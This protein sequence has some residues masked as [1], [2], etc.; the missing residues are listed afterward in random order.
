MSSRHREVNNSSAKTRREKKQDEDLLLFREMFK[1]EKE[2]NLSLLQQESVEL[3]PGQGTYQLHKIPL[4]KKDFLFTESSKNDYDWLKTPPATP[5]FPSLEMEV[6]D[7]NM[8]FH[9]EIP[10]LHPFKPSRFKDKSEAAKPAPKPPTSKSASSSQSVTPKKGSNSL[11]RETAFLQEPITSSAKTK[12][13]TLSSNKRSNLPANTTKHLTARPRTP[14]PIQGFLDM[15]RANLIASAL[16][17]QGKESSGK[18]RETSCSSRAARDQEVE[19]VMQGKKNLAMKGRNN[20]TKEPAVVEKVLNV[21]RV[22]DGEKDPKPKITNGVWKVF[23]KFKSR[24]SQCA[25]M[26]GCQE[27]SRCT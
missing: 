22:A 8:V 2:R 12:Q 6:N 25:K 9:R 5:L 7:P 4:G 3:E 23:G 21:R 26:H 14:P 16:I 13:A 11:S 17:V 24:D 18:P 27:H 1:R 20:G 10:L 19:I 15:P